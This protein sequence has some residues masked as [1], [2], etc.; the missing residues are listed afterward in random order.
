MGGLAV[1]RMDD[2]LVSVVAVVGKG[3]LRWRA[4][5][6]LHLPHHGV[7][8]FALFRTGRWFDGHNHPA[9]VIHGGVRIVAGDDAALLLD[10]DRVGIGGDDVLANCRFSMR[11]LRGLVMLQFV[12]RL[13]QHLAAALGTA[14]SLGQGVGVGILAVVGVFLPVG[15]FHLGKVGVECPQLLL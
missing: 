7:E 5:G 15:R 8:L 3:R 4:S 2:G 14:Q 9:G 10:P 13:G 6:E 12:Q 1:F 11:A